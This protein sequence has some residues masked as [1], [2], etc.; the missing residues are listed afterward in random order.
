[1]DPMIVTKIILSFKEH[2]AKEEEDKMTFILNP[3]Y[4]DDIPIGFFDGAVVDNICGIGIYLKRSTDHIVKAHF[5]GG[6]GNNMKAEL[7][8]LWG[9]LL[10]SSYFSIKELMVAGDSKVPSTG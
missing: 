1:M 10:F 4:F 5:A 6:N 7:L 9:L 3:I 2:S 8:G